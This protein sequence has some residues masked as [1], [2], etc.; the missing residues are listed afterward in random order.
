MQSGGQEREYHLYV[1]RSYDTSKPTPLVL[2]FHGLGSNAF[3]Q[4]LASG[5]PAKSESAGFI[6]VTPQGTNDPRQWHVQSSPFELGYTDDIGFVRDLIGELSRSLCIDPKRIYATGLSN[7]AAMTSL[8]GCELNDEI[9]AIAPVAGSPY[10]DLC[11]TKGPMPIVIFHGTGDWVVPF[12]GGIGPI[13]PVSIP[14]NLKRWAEHNGCNMTLKTEE[15]AS[16]V[17]REWYDGCTNGADAELYVI[18]GGGH[19]WP[20]SEDPPAGPGQDDTF[21]QRDRHHLGL[22]QG[23][24]QA[25]TRR[26]KRVFDSLARGAF[27]SSRKSYWRSC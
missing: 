6:L 11:R 14:E 23:A 22:F 3:Q 12:N 25:L 21:D 5:M 18:H 19:T 10:S 9:A 16:D 20:G 15:V 4:D 8:L 27:A 24:S 13:D 1:P 7:G 2:N 26:S 17:T